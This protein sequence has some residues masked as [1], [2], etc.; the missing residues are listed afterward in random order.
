MKN[1]IKVSFI[2]TMI[3]F[4]L[5]FV[6]AQ[7]SEP[8]IIIDPVTK[9][10]YISWGDFDNIWESN[11]ID[12]YIDSQTN[13]WQDDTQQDNMEQPNQNLEE[14]ILSLQQDTSPVNSATEFDLALKWMYANW[15]TKYNDS[16]EYRPYD[17]IT[18]E[19][20]AKMIAQAYIKFWY[21]QVIKNNNCNFQ[22]SYKIN[23][24]LTQ[25]IS[26]VCRRDIIKW[27]QDQFMPQDNLTKW[28]ILA[29]IIRMFQQKL[30]NEIQTPRRN[31]YYLKAKA[32][33]ITKETNLNNLDNPTSRFEIALL[34]YRLKNIVENEQLRAI[35]LDT[36]NKIQTQYTQTWSIIMPGQDNQSTNLSNLFVWVNVNNDPE[37][38]EAINRMYDNWLTQFS[39]PATYNPFWSLTRD[40]SAKVLDIFS[41]LLN[42]S[43]NNSWYIPN[44][45]TFT[46]LWS[47]D[48]TLK[49]HI[50]NVCSKWLMKWSNW[51]FKPTESMTKAQFVSSLIRMFEGQSLDESVFPR[52][53]NYFDK[54]IELGIVSASDWVNFDNL[55]SRYEVALFI[56]RFKVKYIMLNNINQSKIQDEIISTVPWSIS[57]W[58]NNKPQAN[59]YVDINMI[60]NSTFNIWYIE[61]LG[62]RYKVVK[63]TIAKYN[64]GENSFVRYGDL[65]DLESDSKIWN[66]SFIIGNWYLIESTV[67]IDNQ[68]IHKIQ[69][70]SDTS[71]YYQINQI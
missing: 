2:S 49:T 26:N 20:S 68:S 46:D 28:Q 57:T 69:Q 55:I 43:K 14:Q 71:A 13:T 50:Q 37:L 38:I 60:N 29:I 9:K 5:S 48:E 15:I 62:N 53:K 54:A 35:S 7:T 45:C 32:I 64:I 41:N 8:Q 10:I 34:I 36:I 42:L 21:S 1:P 4:T 40:A 24:E 39:N 33:W 51:L 23:P 18:R 61:L 44:E 52:W 65:F 56:Y 3:L 25:Y 31:E 66:I 22:D 27:S 70:I 30:S 67:R 17:N 11:F 12:S 19:E 59:V 6:M 58:A 63:N 16:T 47:T